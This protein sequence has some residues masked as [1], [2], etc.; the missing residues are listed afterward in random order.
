MLEK[1]RKMLKLPSQ[2]NAATLKQEDSAENVASEGAAAVGSVDNAKDKKADNNAG[3]G[4]S[5]EYYDGIISPIDQF[6][7]EKK[8]AKASTL[9]KLPERSCQRNAPVVPSDT[10][11]PCS[12]RKSSTV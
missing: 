8:K 6:K 11:P 10:S 4:N 7:D 5:T 9:R 12:L 3:N 1:L 2:E